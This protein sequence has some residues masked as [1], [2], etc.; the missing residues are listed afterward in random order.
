MISKGIAI[1]DFAIEG[2]EVALSE[3]QLRAKLEPLD[4]PERRVLLS[5]VYCHDDQLWQVINNAKYTNHAQPPSTGDRQ[6]L[7]AVGGQ[8]ASGCP[9]DAMFALRDIAPGDEITE[10]YST[11]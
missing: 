9:D 11:Y 4:I 6:A 7:L 10:D 1:L 3:A 8:P 2:C 5:H